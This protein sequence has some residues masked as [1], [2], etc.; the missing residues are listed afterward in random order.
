MS[1]KPNYTRLKDWF[2]TDF[3]DFP[4]AWEIQHRTGTVLDHDHECSSRPEWGML[5]DCGAMEKRW[6]WLNENRQHIP[7]KLTVKE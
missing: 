5:C 4:T 3:V 2:L 7:D 1:V 6:A